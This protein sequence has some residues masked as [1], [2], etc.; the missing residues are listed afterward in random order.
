MSFFAQ[1]PLDEPE[2]PLTLRSFEASQNAHG[3]TM[4]L[5]GMSTKGFRW[6]EIPGQ[7]VDLWVTLLSSQRKALYKLREV[8]CKP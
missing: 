1:Q 3:D 8:F 6:N 5:G 4:T 7:R 2:A